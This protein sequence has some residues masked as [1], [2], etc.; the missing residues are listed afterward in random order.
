MTT[1]TISR[2]VRELERAGMVTRR[3]DPDDGCVV[4]IEST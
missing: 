2:V 4:W 3:R 1:S